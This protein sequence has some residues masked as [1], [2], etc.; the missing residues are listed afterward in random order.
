LRD[1]E[2]YEHLIAKQRV[3]SL[4][5]KENMSLSW[6]TLIYDEKWL[7]TSVDIE[8]H[9]GGDVE[10]GFWLTNRHSGAVAD[11]EKVQAMLQAMR[12]QSILFTELRTWMAS[13]NLGVGLESAIICARSIIRQRLKRCSEEHQAYFEALLA[14]D[15]TSVEHPVLRQQVTS[16]L[17]Q[18]L[19][20]GDWQ[21]IAQVASRSIEQQVLSIQQPQSLPAAS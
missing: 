7:R 21:T 14:E 12:L 10:A 1:I 16:Y 17:Q 15:K 2:D 9:F 5:G 6:E 20:P 11:P 8:A 13:W 18:M 19:T 3:L 4:K